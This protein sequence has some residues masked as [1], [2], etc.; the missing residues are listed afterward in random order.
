MADSKLSIR[1][2]NI[3][4]NPKGYWKGLAAIE[5]LASAAKVSEQQAKDWLKRQAIWQIYLP[6]P[7][8][9]PRPKFDIATPNEV[10]QADL[11]FLPHDRVGRKTFRYALTVV[12]VASRYKEAEPLTSK[13]AA[14]VA[15]GLARI[16]KRSPLK[17]P[18]LLQVDPGREVMGSVSQLLAK[19]F[20]QVRR[21]RVDIHRDQGIVERWNRTLAERLFRHQYA[22]EMRLPSGQRSTEWV[23]RL[24]GVV[25]A[26]NGE[27]TRLTG[28]K[29]SDA[30]K[31][32]TVAQK[33]SSVV[34]ARPV[35][36]KEQ[37]VPSG[38]GVRFLYQPGELEGGR[39]RATDPVWS[40]DVYRLGRS[41]TK[42]DEPVLYYLQD[43]PQRGFVREELLVVPPDTQLPPDGVLRR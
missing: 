12:D 18:K 1:L 2:A 32:K 37:K 4:Y 30:I 42:S 10:H 9:M 34:P 21:G 6:A 23:A 27:V 43:G 29:P 41:V 7:R 25:A 26:L 31:A 5:K 15:D 36:L 24:P 28:K 13:T 22:Q 39:R 11:L 20:V 14:E 16:Y 38:V 17:W 19:H 40:L 8:R 33:P 3:Y 35:G